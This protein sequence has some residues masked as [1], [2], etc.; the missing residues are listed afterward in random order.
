MFHLFDLTF[1]PFAFEKKGL[2]DLTL[3]FV[4]TIGP[5]VY[6]GEISIMLVSKVTKAVGAWVFCS[7]N[8][9]SHLSVPTNLAASLTMRKRSDVT[10]VSKKGGI[11]TFISPRVRSDPLRSLGPD[12]TGDQSEGSELTL[13]FARTPYLG[14]K[15]S[16]RDH[17]F[18]LIAGPAFPEPPRMAGIR[19]RVGSFCDSRLVR[20]FLQLEG[21]RRRHLPR[22][23]ERRA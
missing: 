10:T 22:R 3:S 5:E 17:A 12:V 1:F 6:K 11:H 20:S 19:S 4:K 8:R 21:L 13:V 7:L 23:L 18:G 16:F 2:C 9:H 14:F 15:Q